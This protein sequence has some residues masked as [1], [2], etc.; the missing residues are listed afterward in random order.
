MELISRPSKVR[1][2]GNVL[3]KR[4]VDE[5][6]TN[7]SIVDLSSEEEDV[8]YT[9][10]VMGNA[11][12]PVSITASVPE[13]KQGISSNAV[14]TMK[15]QG[16]NVPCSGAELK[17]YVNGVLTDTETTNNN[18]QCTFSI[19]T[20]N[21]GSVELKVEFLGN[22]D[23]SKKSFVTTGII[24]RK[25]IAHCNSYSRCS[26]RSADTNEPIENVA[27]YYNGDFYGYT[28]SDGIF[29]GYSVGVHPYTCNFVKEEHWFEVIYDD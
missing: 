19:P 15:E 10:V 18:G 13:L 9:V 5:Y 8:P 17:Y 6:L 1:A 25:V 4:P 12:S 23:Y 3:E 7:H 2:L 29:P 11:G 14:F 22:A 21:F 28:N 20:S 24:L 27:F 26:C 16:S